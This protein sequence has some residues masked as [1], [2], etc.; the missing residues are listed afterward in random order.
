MRN[1]LEGSGK[2]SSL[3]KHIYFVLPNLPLFNILLIKTVY[4]KKNPNGII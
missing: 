1:D 3:S 2:N 4:D